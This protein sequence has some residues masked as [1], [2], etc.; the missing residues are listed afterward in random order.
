MSIT[1]SIT[2]DMV[3]SEDAAGRHGCRRPLF[4]PHHEAVNRRAGLE[5]QLGADDYGMEPRMLER[6]LD[7]CARMVVPAV[8]PEAVFFV[9]VHELLDGE[10]QAAVGTQRIGGG[11]D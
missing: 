9:A 3:F 1:R 8:R 2:L 7:V 4:G 6:A 10:H 5:P 11:L